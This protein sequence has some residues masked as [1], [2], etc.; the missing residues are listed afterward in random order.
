MCT[1]RTT[2]PARFAVSSSRGDLQRIY[3]AG[4]HWT[5]QQ[6]FRCRKCAGADPRTE[7]F[8]LPPV[9]L[10]CTDAEGKTTRREVKP[11]ILA[12]TASR[13]KLV[14]WCRLR[15]GVR[16]FTLTGIQRATVTRH[17]FTRYQI[18]EIGEPPTWRTQSISENRFGERTIDSSSRRAMSVKSRGHLASSSIRH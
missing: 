8:R 2:R 3:P 11:M 5:A 15:D 10:I 14:A 9:N 17:P 7:M 16:W 18:E 12:L 13:W 4:C 6:R 1:A